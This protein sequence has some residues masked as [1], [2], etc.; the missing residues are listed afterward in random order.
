MRSLFALLLVA[1]PL[2]GGCARFARA[3]QLEARL[4]QQEDQI[5]AYQDRVQTLESERDRL[6]A[7]A[8]SGIQLASA[9]STSPAGFAAIDSIAF[10]PL[11]TGGRDTD[12]VP[13]DDVIHALVQPLD[14]AGDLIKT[15]GELEVELLDVAARE[16]DRTVQT[17]RFNAEETAERWE[18]G[19]FG[20]GFRVKLRPSDGTLPT[21]GL[22]LAHFRTG[23]GRQ[24]DAS[25][26]VKLDLGS[27]SQ[28][29]RRFLQAITEPAAEPAQ[30][31]A[32]PRPNDRDAAGSLTA[33]GVNPTAPNEAPKQT[34]F[35]DDLVRDPS[36][37]QSFAGDAKQA[38]RRGLS[39]VA[40]YA[41]DA[42]GPIPQL[43][44]LVEQMP[45]E[46]PVRELDGEPM[47]DEPYRETPMSNPFARFLDE[48]DDD[49]TEPLRTS[50]NR[51]KFDGPVVR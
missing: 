30:R 41:D 43:A 35:A 44:D 19:L 27:G 51:T 45:D 6:A 49:A 33:F 28:E 13:G 3:D 4:R 31:S 38:T 18:S 34:A 39:D 26:A 24:F 14:A 37:P 48:L 10:A 20:S 16:E 8:E 46:L 9:T 36:G 1:L 12:A 21:D 42:F 29:P 22:L 32:A 47:V 11:V 7:Q 5:A 15:S 40:D 2:F 17:W 50:E 23:D 25:R